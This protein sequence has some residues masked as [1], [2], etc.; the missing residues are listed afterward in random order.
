MLHRGEAMSNARYKHISQEE[1]TVKVSSQVE[2]FEDTLT[3]KEYK[4]F[5][6]GVAGTI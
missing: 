1:G 6:V 2:W 4:K 5:V 3:L